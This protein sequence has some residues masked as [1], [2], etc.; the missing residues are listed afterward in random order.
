MRFLLVTWCFIFVVRENCNW[1]EKL[2]MDFKNTQRRI[3]HSV[4][5]SCLAGMD[6]LKN[7]L[8]KC[9]AEDILG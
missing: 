2:A 5:T 1:D 4:S 6:M 8:C 3:A 9:M 7:E